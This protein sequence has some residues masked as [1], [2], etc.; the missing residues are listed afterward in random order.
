MGLAAVRG[1]VELGA[2][3][4]VIDR[5]ADCVAGRDDLAGV[6]VVEAELRDHAAVEA[7][8]SSVD[9]EL[10]SLKAVINAAGIARPDEASVEMSETTWR[11]SIDENVSGL[12]WSCQ[13][14]GRRMLH[15]GEGSI[16]NLAS[17]CGLQVARRYR[18][19][20]YHA[21]KAGVIA[22]TRALAAEWGDRGVRV[23]SIAPGAFMIDAPEELSGSD[24]DQRMA[25]SARIA[26][27]VP[28]RRVGRSDEIVAAVVYLASDASS[29]VTGAT[30]VVD[31]GRILEFE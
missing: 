19:V 18:A 30:L 13:Q 4:A 7:A 3:V 28:L 8:Y 24:S 20:H 12:F 23:N 22:M 29:Y 6:V 14:A 2:A 11:A 25:Q 17:L 1:L 21:A 31:G 15:L 26:S 16:V 9:A 27:H 10:P 5:P